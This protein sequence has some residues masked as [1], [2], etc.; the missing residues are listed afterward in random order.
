[1]ESEATLFH[2][3]QRSL[4]ASDSAVTEKKMFGTTA[5]CVGGKI[6]MFPWK[7]MLVLKLPPERVAELVS[8]GR[9]QLFDPGHGRASRSWAAL[10]PGSRSTWPRLARE[11]RAFVEE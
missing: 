9:A 10:S 8:S 3:K 1:L 2:A 5:L 7:D 6:F 4:L 11:A